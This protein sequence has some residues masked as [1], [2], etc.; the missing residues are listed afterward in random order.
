MCKKRERFGRNWKHWGRRES[1]EPKRRFS[2][3]VMG[4]WEEDNGHVGSNQ[5]SVDTCWWQTLRKKPLIVDLKI[6]E[7]LTNID[8]SVWE[9]VSFLCVCGRC[10]QTACQ[11]KVTPSALVAECQDKYRQKSPRGVRR[12]TFPRKL[13]PTVFVRCSVNRSMTALTHHWRRWTLT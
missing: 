1:I 10:L 7:N 12:K 9:N 6:R 8:S 4:S 11:N 13:T 2:L 3:G 5:G